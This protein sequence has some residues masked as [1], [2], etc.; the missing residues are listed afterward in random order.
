LISEVGNID[1]KTV[2][3]SP[4]RNI[5][6]TKLEIKLEDIG[7]KTEIANKYKDNVA[8]FSVH[9]DY[10]ILRLRGIKDR[11]INNSNVDECLDSLDS[12][13]DY[14]VE[15]DLKSLKQEGLGADVISQSLQRARGFSHDDVIQLNAE[16]DFEGT[17]IAQYEKI[18]HEAM[19]VLHKPGSPEA[20]EYYFIAL[21]MAGYPVSIEG[22]LDIYMPNYT[23]IFGNDASNSAMASQANFSGGNLEIG[24]NGYTD[25]SMYNRR[26]AE[27]A[28]LFTQIMEKQLLAAINNGDFKNK[29][30]SLSEHSDLMKT[31][32]NR[33][34]SNKQTQLLLVPASL[35]TYYAFDYD[36][37]GNGLSLVLKHKNIGVFNSI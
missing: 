14:N 16:I 2:Q 29:D 23:G 18:P 37:A 28:A 36:D 25:Q 20:H 3:R 22:E 1:S 35:M 11:L 15:E 12:L 13:S 30:I 26:V 6:P 10:E 21:D 34:L 4:T 17:D 9:G 19:Y 8:T 31:M 32:F 27:K 33:F 5:K 24:Y 7:V